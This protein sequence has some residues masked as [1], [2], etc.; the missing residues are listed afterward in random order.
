[1][2]FLIIALA[3]AAVSGCG[4]ASTPTSPTDTVPFSTV[5]LRVGTG[6]EV[7]SGRVIA[8]EYTGWLYSATAVDN[9][10]TQFDSTFDPGRDPYVLLAGGTGTIAGFSQA[11]LGM[12][13]GGIRR[14]VIPPSLGYGAQGSPPAI[15]GNATL[16]FEIEVLAIQPQ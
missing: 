16:V 12:R 15:P 2:R 13:V 5:N 4:G 11:V 1:M 10:G 7:V 14:V 9:K 8:V 6:A 3:L